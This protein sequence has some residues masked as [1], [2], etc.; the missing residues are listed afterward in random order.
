MKY[1][2]L[3]ARPDPD[4]APGFFHLLAGSAHASEA[5]L[6]DWNLGPTEA[7]TMLYGVDGDADAF[8]SSATDTPG[9]ESVDIATA[10]GER[11]YMLVEARPS[12][13]PLF[14]RMVAAMTRAGLVVLTPVVYRDGRVTGHVVGNPAALQATLDAAPDAVDVTV[15]EVGRFRGPPTEPAT[16]LSERQREAVETALDLGYYDLPSEA[17]HED[18]AAALDCAPSTASEHLKR[19]EA[20]LV[21][22][23]LP[24]D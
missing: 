19:A 12:A 3:T 11:F 21:C 23:G 2:R 20:K 14:R 10:G 15:E 7:A 17:T 13:V 5:R 6:L 22:A 4:R 16:D 18:I 8:R 24:S 9:I 1:L